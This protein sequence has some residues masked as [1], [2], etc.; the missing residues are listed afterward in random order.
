MAQYT[1]QSLDDLAT[2]FETF[3]SDQLASMRWQKS[4]KGKA[5]CQTKATVWADAADII[6]NTVFIPKQI[7]DQ[8]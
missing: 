5:E 1:I 7:G 8:T 3:A 2:T 4:A 6:R